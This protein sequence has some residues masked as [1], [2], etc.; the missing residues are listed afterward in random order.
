[1]AYPG[2]LI[3]MMLGALAGLVAGAVALALL[4]AGFEMLPPKW[5]RAFALFAIGVAV[6][7]LLM[8]SPAWTVILSREGTHGQPVTLAARAHL[9]REEREVMKMER[10]P[11]PAAAV[12]ELSDSSSHW[13]EMTSVPLS[14]QYA[15]ETQ[16]SGVQ[17]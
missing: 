15:T 17:M 6:V 14:V 16:P 4:A 5:S 12:L 9:T 3:V 2:G 8:V 1:M 11:S 13:L 10:A 7:A